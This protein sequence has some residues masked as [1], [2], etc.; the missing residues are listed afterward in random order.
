[1]SVIT[2]LKYEF[3]TQLVKRGKNYGNFIY[4][5]E[6]L[7]TP[8]RVRRATIRSITTR[9]VQLTGWDETIL[10]QQ[11]RS[12]DTSDTFPILKDQVVGSILSLVFDILQ[13]TAIAVSD[14]LF[15]KDSVCP[16]H[17]F[18]KFTVLPMYSLG[19]SIM[20]LA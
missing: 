16:F 3:H 2:P 10:P 13:G 7:S 6:C 20:T 8:N 11:Q 9:K 4:G 15:L 19:S 14:G 5:N 17:L 18:L 12:S 1:M